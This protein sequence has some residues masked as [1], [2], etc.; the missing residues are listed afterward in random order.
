MSICYDLAYKEKLMPEPEVKALVT[1]FLD[2]FGDEKPCFYTNGN[3]YE[4]QSSWVDLA[5]NPA[6]DA[7]FD[8]GVLILGQLKAGCLW[9]EDED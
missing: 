3:Y 4:G 8:T 2:H 1:R 7:T 5:W 6:T 9:V